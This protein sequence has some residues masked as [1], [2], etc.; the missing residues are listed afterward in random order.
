[1]WLS[2]LA[3]MLLGGIAMVGCLV[4]YLPCRLFLPILVVVFLCLLLSVPRSVQTYYRSLIHTQEHRRYLLANGATH[5]ES[6]IPSVRRALRTSFCTVSWTRTSP[7]P[8][9]TLMMFCGMLMGG[10]TLTA[11]LAAVVVLWA[12]IVATSILS[13]VLAMWIADRWLFDKQE[14]LTTTKQ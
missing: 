1:M 5:L 8:F 13:S 14:N 6:V 3:G 4:L 12:A 10:A 2:A 7:M 11:A 9:A